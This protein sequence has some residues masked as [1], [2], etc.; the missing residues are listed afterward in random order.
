MMGLGS[1]AHRRPRT[2]G[3]SGECRSVPDLRCMTVQSPNQPNKPRRSPCN[4]PTRSQMDFDSR[5]CYRFW[6]EGDTIWGIS[7]QFPWRSESDTIATNL[8]VTWGMSVKCGFGWSS[9]PRMRRI[10]PQLGRHGR[11][12]HPGLGEFD[13]RAVHGFSA[14]IIQLLSG[15]D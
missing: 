11:L 15:P 9:L 6:P 13:R 12:A 10:R 14:P 5:V 4:V 1:E 2:R 7:V 3:M 8:D